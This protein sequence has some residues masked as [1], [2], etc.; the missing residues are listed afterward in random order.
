M[1]KL[2]KLSDSPIAVMNM[3]IAGIQIINQNFI[4]VNIIIHLYSLFFQGCLFMN[5]A[6]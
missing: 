4:E 2:Y 6:Y 3:S 1:V 5:L